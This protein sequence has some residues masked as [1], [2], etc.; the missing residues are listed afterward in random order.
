MINQPRIYQRIWTN[1]STAITARASRLMPPHDRCAIVLIYSAP[2][3]QYT[4]FLFIRIWL[5]NRIATPTFCLFFIRCF[6]VIVYRRTFVAHKSLRRDGYFIWC[7]RKMSCG[8]ASNDL[9]QRKL[10]KCGGR[11][12]IL[13]MNAAIQ[14]YSALMVRVSG[15][16]AS[17]V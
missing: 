7:R 15:R 3:T 8:V 11:L 4:I 10:C 17:L 6:A 12:F 13:Y 1:I 14:I 9:D 16:R 2:H 5:R